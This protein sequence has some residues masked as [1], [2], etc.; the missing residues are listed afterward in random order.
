MVLA[1]SRVPSP[2][3]SP[4]LHES[5]QIW[6]Q[7]PALPLA[8]SVAQG[9]CGVLLANKDTAPG[10]VTLV[11]GFKHTATLHNSLSA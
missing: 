2:I 1:A 3:P 6:S 4:L 5:R 10:E 11:R 7:M 9:L 8:S